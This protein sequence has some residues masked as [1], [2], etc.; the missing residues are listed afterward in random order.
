M[1]IIDSQ[2]HSWDAEHP[3]RPWPKTGAPHVHLAEP[4]TYED[5]LVRMKEAGVDRAVLVPPSWQGDNNDYSLEAA[6]VY[7]QHFGVMGRLQLDA[8]ASRDWMTRWKEIPGM[9]G[10]R[11]TF[12]W[13]RDK[14]WLYDGSADWFW[15]AA[16]RTGL[17]VMVMGPDEM[18]KFGEIARTHPGLKLII[19]HM[20]CAKWIATAGGIPEAVKNTISLA[21][22]PN[23]FVKLSGLPDYSSEPYPFK[24]LH[25]PIRRVL[26]AF[27]PERAFWG[28]DL[29]RVLATCSY[30]EAVTAFTEEMDFLKGEDLAWVMGKGIARCLGMR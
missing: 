22:Y 1:L 4:L 17:P 10:V 18:K 8:P 21:A 6:S 15:D 19:D 5:L 29:S 20:G 2:V 26:D 23:V 14:Q 11:Q 16:E 13:E 9:L 12:V 28:T 25:D 7:P 30:R 27:G 3:D 24:D